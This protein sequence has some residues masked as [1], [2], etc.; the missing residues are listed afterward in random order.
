MAQKRHRSKKWISW[1]IILALLIGA[2]VVCYFVYDSYFKEKPKNE[3]N[4]V[5]QSQDK[6][7]KKNSEEKK[8]EEEKKETVKK[9]EVVQYDGAD[10]NASNEITGVITYAGVSGGNLM[11]RINIDQYLN[12]GTCLLAL[13]QG[14]GLVYSA[15]AGVV[16]SAS[17]STCEGFNV[18]AAGLAAG[19]YNIVISINSNGKTGEIS[20][21]V[22]I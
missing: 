22:E 10:P 4:T 13:R 12:G 1:V 19:K 21:E 16:D 6:D 7:E 5:E 18:P 2:G 17:T 20:G 14:G 15:E 8:S 9:E 11:I 3:P